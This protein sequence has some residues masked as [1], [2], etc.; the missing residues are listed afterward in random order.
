MARRNDPADIILDI[1]K[2]IIAIIIG[3]IIIK[4]LWPL[5]FS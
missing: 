2:I 5:L 3:A 1:I 4:A